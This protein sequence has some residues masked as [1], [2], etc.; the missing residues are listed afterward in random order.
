MNDEK[1]VIYQYLPCIY[2][3]TSNQ[4]GKTQLLMQPN[5]NASVDLRG[6]ERVCNKKTIKKHDHYDT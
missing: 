1:Y 5:L 4:R 3:L 6:C 2:E